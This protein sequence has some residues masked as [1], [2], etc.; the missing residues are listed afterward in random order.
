VKQTRAAEGPKPLDEPK[1][2][3]TAGPSER[4]NW[5]GS[6]R[7]G[8]GAVQNQGVQPQFYDARSSWKPRP[9]VSKFVRFAIFA[10]PIVAASGTTIF[11]GQRFFDNTWKHPA[12][13]A[14]FAFIFLLATAITA[15]TKKGIDRFLPLSMLVRSNLA[16]PVEAPNRV[17]LALRIG[18]SANR[19]RV[20]ASF[21]ENGLSLDPQIAAEQVLVLV[22]ELNKHDRRTRGHSE[23]V[24]AL[25]DVIAQELG[26][27]PKDRE[28]LRWG[29]L[30]HDVGKLAVPASLLNKEGRPTDEEWEMLKTHPTEGE[31]RLEGVRP[32]LGDWVRC[33][34]EHHERFDGL[35]Y[36]RGLRASE[37]PLGSRIVAVA[38]AFE[39]M[40]SVRS[41]KKAMSFDDARAELAR[42]AGTHFDPEVVRALLRVGMSAKGY[43]TGFF[44]TL[45]NR[46][47][48]GPGGSVTTAG[49]TFA[50]SAAAVVFGATVVVTQPHVI[51]AAPKPVPVI[52]LALREPTTTTST[53]TSTTTT[54]TTTTT[55]PLPTS[56]TAASIVPAPEPASTTV[57]EPSTTTTEATIIPARTTTTTTELPAPEP[58]TTVEITVAPVI[59]TIPTTEPTTTSTST[60]STTPSTTTTTTTALPP[61]PVVA[62]V[63]PTTAPSTVPKSSTPPPTAAPVLLTKPRAPT[64]VANV[65]A[66][67]PSSPTPAAPVALAVPTATATIL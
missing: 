44:S 15:R 3:N 1:N 29:S 66:T 6:K 58:P 32:W 13:A 28:L 16:F 48:A 7:N 24:R 9:L 55:A 34:W 5:R 17:K 26:L 11:L 30:L 59:L 20:T 54:S 47:Q 43:G 56:T 35:G 21:R 4:T 65:A 37:L 41:Y 52:A 60:T 10:A 67:P 39:V 38:D 31:W 46:L 33:A 61:E 27:S 22:E 40:T 62:F 8:A 42:C 50:S 25:S 19:E 12:K 63:V 51:A 36:P 64:T 14:W 45:L 57:P 18:N 2:L 23:K 49:T 53:T